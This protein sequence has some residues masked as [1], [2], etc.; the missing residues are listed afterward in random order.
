ML[1]LEHITPFFPETMRKFPRSMLREYLQYKILAQIFD[2]PVGSKLSFLGG[3][4]LRIIHGNARFSED[5]DF[6]N[7]GV[8]PEEFA[9]LA[10]EIRKKLALEGVA[11]RTRVVAKNAFRCY[12]NIPAILH[13]EHLSPH[14]E[15]TI[16][17]QIDTLPHHFSYEPERRI[18]NKFDV[19]S[20]ILVTP[21]TLILAQKIV[22]AFD[23]KRAKGR[24]FYDIVFLL[25]QNILPDSAYLA[26]T[27]GIRS[28]AELKHHILE[29][30]APLD[31]HKLASDVEPFLFQPK[32]KSRVT[33]FRE[34]ISQMPW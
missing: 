9:K 6:D 20:E 15:E 22:A 4:A 5:L 32:D 16:L 30:C 27:I 14:P 28:P 21:A 23:R 13:R 3:T 1:S 18:L 31:F 11:T 24:D 17:I 10:N 34:Y 7:F 8:S 2:T 19:F 25:S 29:Q 12:I 26:A 33:L